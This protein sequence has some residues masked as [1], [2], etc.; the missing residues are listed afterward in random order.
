[1]KG[2][3]MGKCVLARVDFR[4]IHGQVITKW[5]KKT[6]A[7]KIII[8]DNILANDAFMGKIYANAAPKG[9]KVQIN[10]VEEAAVRWKENQF[11]DGNVM[12]L[13]KN[14]G[15]CHAA[16]KDGIT[17]E[18]LQLGGVPN[19]PGKKKITSEIFVNS[20]E[21]QML[22]EIAAEGT[23]IYIQAVPEKQVMNYEEIK[24]RMG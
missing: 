14:I 16:M 10:T 2:E 7:E 12:I 1:M 24:K 4:L 21:M 15:V 22:K 5:V 13:F 11:G 9:I 17:L 18:R 6:G 8:V 3:K 20:D 19:E 23:E